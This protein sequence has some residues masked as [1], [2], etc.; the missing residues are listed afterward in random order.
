MRSPLT[1]FVWGANR[2]VPV[3][4]TDLSIA[5]EAFDVALNPTRAKVTIG[6]RVL[7]VDDLGAGT[8]GGGLFMTYLARKEQLAQRVGAGALSALGITGI[9]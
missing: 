6:L 3:R 5:E 8:R 7:T 1:L 9:P 4:V 2:I